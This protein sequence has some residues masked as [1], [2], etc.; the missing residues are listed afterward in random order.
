MK[1]KQRETPDIHIPKEPFIHTDFYEYEFR[2]PG[3][4][5]EKVKFLDV[6]LADKVLFLLSQLG[7]PR[8]KEES[9]IIDKEINGLEKETLLAMCKMLL[10]SNY[11]MI[12]HYN[13]MV[14]VNRDNVA[15]GYIATKNHILDIVKKQINERANQASKAGKSRGRINKPESKQKIKE[16]WE[17]GKFST[18][19]RCAEEEWEACGFVSPDSAYRHLVSLKDK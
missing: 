12:C 14:S 3:P 11:S 7:R 17:T 5:N 1:K 8:C 18:K 9:E 19:K 15:I 6:Y 2:D 16:Q 13:E 4:L 10:S